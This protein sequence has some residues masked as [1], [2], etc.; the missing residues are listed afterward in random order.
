MLK[1]SCN[2]AEKRAFDIK[3]G[4]NHILFD[5]LPLDTY[6]HWVKQAVE[7]QGEDGKGGHR[8][9]RW[10]DERND[11]HEMPPKL[12][13]TDLLTYSSQYQGIFESKDPPGTFSTIFK[14]ALG[15]IAA[16]MELPFS[17]RTVTDDH[18]TVQGP[19]WGTLT[20]TASMVI[21]TPFILCC[22]IKDGV[23]V[24]EVAGLSRADVVS[25]F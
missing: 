20:I 13:T 21:N 2:A 10:F 15:V 7:S 1:T 12:T 25:Y 24:A 9:M 23:I 4:S 3:L 8:R 5:C 14:Y 22:Q 6:F 17:S 18:L 11:L 16:V 19:H